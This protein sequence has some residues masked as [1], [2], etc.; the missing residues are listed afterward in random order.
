MTALLCVMFLVTGLVLGL[1]IG[2]M[3]RRRDAQRR[4]GVL[5]VDPVKRATVRLPES[6]VPATVSA[7]AQDAK[8]RY[9]QESMADGYT[10]AEAEADWEE[11]MQTANN[12]QPIG[13]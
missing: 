8:D 7:A 13:G 1:W 10:Q 11:M 4:E 2:E 9:V 6:S 12:D 3:G 5:S